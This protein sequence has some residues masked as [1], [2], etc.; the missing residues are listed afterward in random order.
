MTALAARCKAA[1]VTR[2]QM[3]EAILLS[4]WHYHTGVMVMPE[5]TP[6]PAASTITPGLSKAP[7]AD[8][9]IESIIL[10]MAEGGFRK[11]E[12]SPVPKQVVELFKGDYQEAARQVRRLAS[13]HKGTP[14][15]E[16]LKTLA[17]RIDGSRPKK[18]TTKKEKEQ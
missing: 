3:L 13:A 11:G 14:A 2:R 7:S 12:S 8:R 6:A 4:D 17:N 18:T 9:G 15:H 5:I 1:G 10:K 16:D